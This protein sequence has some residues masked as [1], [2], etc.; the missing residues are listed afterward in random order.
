MNVYVPFLRIKQFIYFYFEAC[1]SFFKY[2]KPIL[3]KH[4]NSADEATDELLFVSLDEPSKKNIINFYCYICSEDSM[5]NQ[6]Y[7]MHDK[8]FCSYACRNQ[9]R[10]MY[11]ETILL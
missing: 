11:D 10:K 5:K 7:L 4:K 1:F 6:V 3:I 8:I 2:K 9:Y